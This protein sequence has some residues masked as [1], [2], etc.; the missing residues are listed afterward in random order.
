MAPS[1]TRKLIER[2]RKLAEL[3]ERG[4]DGERDNAR[5]LLAEFDAR[6]PTLRDYPPRASQL[7]FNVTP[8]QAAYIVA[9][10][11]EQLARRHRQRRNGQGGAPGPNQ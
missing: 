6:H 10:V 7:P 1:E 5:R 3:A 8:E 9:Y 2:R 11:L 4:V